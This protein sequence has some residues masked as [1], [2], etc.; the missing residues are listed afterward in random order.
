MTDQAH[1]KT[2][3][4]LPAKPDEDINNI[5]KAAVAGRPP[6]LKFKKGEYFIGDEEVPLGRR[7]LVYASDWRRGWRKWKDNQIVEDRVVRVADDPR[8]PVERDE[9]DDFDDR[10]N[11][12]VVDGELRDPW[13]YE[14]QLPVEGEQ[15]GERFLFVTT[16]AR[17]RSKTSVA[18]M[19]R[20]SERAKTR[21][22]RSSHSRPSR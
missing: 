4:N 5:Y 21:A 1:E 18:A 10:S 15:T 7:F 19:P 14:N 3:M 17:W 6:T 9:L 16:A 2:N 20:C 8:E 12:P 22:C 11:W 13:C